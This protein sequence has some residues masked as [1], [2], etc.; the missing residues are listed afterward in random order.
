VAKLVQPIFTISVVDDD[1]HAPEQ[2]LA[3]DISMKNSTMR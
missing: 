2:F 3:G 1:I